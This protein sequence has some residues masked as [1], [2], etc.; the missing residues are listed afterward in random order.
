M[1]ARNSIASIEAIPAARAS[2]RLLNPLIGDA[3]EATAVITRRYD[4]H[5]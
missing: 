2:P 5:S 4:S 1:S 3:G